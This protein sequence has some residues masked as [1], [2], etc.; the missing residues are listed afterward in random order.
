MAEYEGN[1]L[2]PPGMGT[3]RWNPDVEELLASTV[4]YSQYGGTV[5]QNTTGNATDN[6]A[7]VLLVGQPM[8]YDDTSKKWVVATGIDVQAFN[9]NAVD[10]SDGD[11]LINLVWKGTIKLSVSGLKGADVNAL[12]T[13]LNGKVDPAYGYLTF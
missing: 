13:T 4:G 8:K 7:N 2:R 10:T 12:A 3:E 6:P 1:V 5:A 9:R 11:H